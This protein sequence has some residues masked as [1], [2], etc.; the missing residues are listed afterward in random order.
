MKDKN[1]EEE[2]RICGKCSKIIPFGMKYF[3]IVKNYEKL[4]L[5]TPNSEPEIEIDE[6]VE[7]VALC[8]D[9]GICFNEENLKMI[10]KAI[11]I[12]G[13]EGRN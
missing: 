7:V 8:K 13:Q 3:S 5:E 2:I 10:L 6:S 1:E 9:C 4:V 11:P 12:R